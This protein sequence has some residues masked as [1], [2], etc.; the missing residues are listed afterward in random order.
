MHCN[1]GV[2]EEVFHR[3]GVQVWNRAVGIC[4]NLDVNGGCV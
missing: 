1:E 2:L 3:M 4:L